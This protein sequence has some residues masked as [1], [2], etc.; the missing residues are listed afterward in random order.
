[1]NE[2]RAGERHYAVTRGDREPVVVVAPDPLT[3]IDWVRH[4]LYRSHPSVARATFAVGLVHD[5]PH[6]DVSR[7][8]QMRVAA[9]QRSTQVQVP[10]GGNEDEVR[11]EIDPNGHWAEVSFEPADVPSMH[12]R[13]AL[14][15]LDSPNPNNQPVTI[16]VAPCHP[17]GSPLSHHTEADA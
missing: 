13:G 8:G 6:R 12:G 4:P 9:V 17:D 1:M 5:L 10:G 3:A 14:V 15:P 7:P 16:T 2:L 11:T